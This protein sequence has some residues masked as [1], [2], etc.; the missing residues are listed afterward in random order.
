MQTYPKVSFSKYMQELV[1]SGQ[2]NGFLPGALLTL[3]ALWKVHHQA[4]EFLHTP[5]NKST[6]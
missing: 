5:V 1:F 6:I 2:R 4:Q 3:I